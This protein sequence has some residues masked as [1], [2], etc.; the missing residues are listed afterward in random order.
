MKDCVDRQET[1]MRQLRDRLKPVSPEEAA[2]L[3]DA[4]G[5]YHPNIKNP[6]DLKTAQERIP[7]QRRPEALPLKGLVDGQPGKNHCRYGI[8]QGSIERGEN[9]TSR[10]QR[11]IGDN[12]LFG[13]DDK[14]FD[15]ARFRVGGALLQ[16]IV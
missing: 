3:A 6:T 1:G 2:L 11:V 7:Q 14:A 4:E 10:R 12:A 5:E 15:R 16:P 9:D 13:Q 8:G